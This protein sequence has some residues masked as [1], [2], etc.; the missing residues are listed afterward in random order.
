MRSEEFKIEKIKKKESNE[1]KDKFSLTCTI[2]MNHVF[3]TEKCFAPDFYFYDG[4]SI[5]SASLSVRVNEK[6]IIIF[7]SNVVE[8]SKN[9]LWFLY[10]NVNLLEENNETPICF[11]RFLSWITSFTKKENEKLIN[12]IINNKKA[13]RNNIKE[14]FKLKKSMGN[15]S[16]TYNMFIE[17]NTPYVDLMQLR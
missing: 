8:N 3:L 17:N 4:C 2:L 14:Y 15:N 9:A 16:Y 13:W 11:I 5:P 10:S 6:T 7:K 12:K 1:I